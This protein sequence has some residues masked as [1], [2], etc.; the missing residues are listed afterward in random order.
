MPKSLTSSAGSTSVIR[1]AI[2][3]RRKNGARLAVTF[4]ALLVI[5][6]CVAAVSV[7][8]SAMH[9]LL[10]LVVRDA[11]GDYRAS[12]QISTS[13]VTDI[14]VNVGVAA[15][16]PG[17]SAPKAAPAPIHGAA[18]VT[19][20]KQRPNAPSSGRGPGRRHSRRSRV[21]RPV[22]RETRPCEPTRIQTGSAPLGGHYVPD[23]HRESRGK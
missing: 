19:P 21:R 9:V 7:G 10:A 8:P 16:Q 15:S 20:P 4:P 18:P 2:S 13:N 1:P 5:A 23:R 3:Y 6:F 17:A 11:H 14:S 22:Q 12:S